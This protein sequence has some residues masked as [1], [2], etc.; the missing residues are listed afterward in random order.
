MSTVATSPPR[1][2]AASAPA[3]RHGVCRLQININGVDYALWPLPG[4]RRSHWALRKPDG[5]K[6]LINRSADG[7]QCTCPDYSFRAPLRPCKHIRALIACQ[8]LPRLRKAVRS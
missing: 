2:N 5:T 8:L 1:A 3:R 4:P 6:Y 7:A